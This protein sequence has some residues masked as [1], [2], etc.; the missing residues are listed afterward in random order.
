VGG[1]ELR[2]GAP[3]R[4]AT[5]KLRLG[6]S[7]TAETADDDASRYG[8][9]YSPR[10]DEGSDAKNLLA[11]LVAISGSAESHLLRVGAPDLDGRGR[12]SARRVREPPTVRFSSRGMRGADARSSVETREDLDR[13][14]L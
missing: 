10:K 8:A 5:T 11:A 7:A 9:R 2:L 13:S 14:A 12:G 3:V 6:G 1:D 4:D